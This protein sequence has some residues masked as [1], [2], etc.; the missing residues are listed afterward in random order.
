MMRGDAQ[1]YFTPLNATGELVQTG[2]I[3]AI[4]SLAA[5][6]MPQLPDVPTLRRTVSTLPIRLGRQRGSAPA[7]RPLVVEMNEDI[8]EIVQK[9]PQIWRKLQ[10]NWLIAAFS[11]RQSNW[12]EIIRSE[13]G[14]CYANIFKGCV[15]L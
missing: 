13:D 2:K 3:R 6:R 11:A 9:T 5:K 8:L 4:A 12:A 1:I 14:P 15:R 7:P 10:A